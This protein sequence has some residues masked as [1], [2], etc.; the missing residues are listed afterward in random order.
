MRDNG[1]VRWTIE[2]SAGTAQDLHDLA[3]GPDP[4]VRINEV[5]GP[6][7]VLGSDRSRSG[8]AARTPGVE[9]A[10]RHSGGG[11]VWLSPGAQ[12]WVDVLVT[13]DDPRHFDDIRRAAHWIGDAWSAALGTPAA[14]W[15]SGMTNVEASRI[16]CFAGVGPGEV[17]LG[18]RKLVG[19]SQ[20][21]TRDW[22][23]FQCVAYHRWNPEDL[24]ANLDLGSVSMELQSEV[25]NALRREVAVLSQLGA[26]GGNSAPGD[27][28]VDDPQVQE[29]NTGL[30]ERFVAALDV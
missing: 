7:V 19:I 21:R 26:T 22:S 13:S 8:L 20:R 16:A 12:L 28:L 9:L 3:M 5:T 25:A 24:L 17:M 15:R 1:L 30:L 14:T 6:A 29:W 23:R 4:L 27:P 2:H 10:R 11:A 18:D